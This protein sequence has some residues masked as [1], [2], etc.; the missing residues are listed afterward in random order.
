MNNSFPILWRKRTIVVTRSRMWTRIPSS[1]II[2]S[3]SYLLLSHGDGH[4]LHLH[5]PLILPLS[6]PPWQVLHHMLFAPLVCSL[7]MR[8]FPGST[9]LV[10]KQP[11]A[12][13]HTV[14][15]ACDITCKQ[16]LCLF[17]LENPMGCC[18]RNKHW[19]IDRDGKS[20]KNI[21]SH[22]FDHQMAPLVFV[23]YLAT[24]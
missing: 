3:H 11:C 5:L 22:K 21:A 2:Q 23:A 16:W 1:C 20:C 12:I 7:Q 17:R 6:S 9:D 4:L 8:F 10:E 18:L 14:A 24:K 13:I 15:L 19:L